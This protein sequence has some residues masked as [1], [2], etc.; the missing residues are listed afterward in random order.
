M[1]TNCQEGNDLY[2]FAVE[3]QHMKLLKLFK[4]GKQML[5]SSLG[6][7]ELRYMTTIEPN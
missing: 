7:F 5:G 6:L 2:R 3:I 4:E 1:I